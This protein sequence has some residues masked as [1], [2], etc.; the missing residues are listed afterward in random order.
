MEHDQ[1]SPP[2]EPQQPPASPPPAPAPN[3]TPTPPPDPATGS[4]AGSPPPGPGRPSH[5]HTCATV[6]V[7]CFLAAGLAIAGVCIML[8]L[9]AYIG[10]QVEGGMA[11][12]LQKSFR[13]QVIHRGTEDSKI[14]VISLT[15]MI[16]G[17]GSY[18]QGAGMA[19]KLVQQLRA[20]GNDSAVRAVVLQVDSPGGGLSASDLIHS[21]VKRLQ[22]RRKTVVAAVGGLAA[23][24]GYWVIAPSDHIV[25]A[26]TGLVGSFGV[27]MMR[28]KI[29][30][31]LGKIGVEPEPLLSTDLKDLGS[32]YRDLSEEER[33][34]FQS[35]LATW[36]E[37][38]IEVIA[39]GRGLEVDAVQPLANGKVYTASQALEYGLIDEIGYFDAAL[40]AARELGKA[41]GAT[42]VRY[43]PRFPWMDFLDIQAGTQAEGSPV[44][45]VQDAVLKSGVPRLEACWRV[46]Q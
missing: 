13:E 38:F 19:H 33:A 32:P 10:Q 21:E 31:L 43:A 26:P 6:S 9:F 42:V 40:K 29:K 18:A 45:I 23:S 16:T 24:G 41:K 46:G 30:D 25:S 35:L 20:A 12:P 3:T 39:A 37:R 14:V 8:A 34:F 2:G 28:F 7:G 1:T 4:Q 15:G 36:H 17:A 11:M 44:K 5:V 22:A 27:A